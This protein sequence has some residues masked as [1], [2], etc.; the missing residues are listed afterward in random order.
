MDKI[1]NAPITSESV[2]E[3]IYNFTQ[4]AFIGSSIREMPLDSGEF[5]NTFTIL[6]AGPLSQQELFI[7]PLPIQRVIYELLTQYIIFFSMNP[8]LPFPPD[9]LA[10]SNPKLLGQKV[11]AYMAQHGWPFPQ[12]FG[13]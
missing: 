2:Q 5:A 10:Q 9:F 6:R 7:Q 8:S 13:Q 1:M 3:L 12:M 4:Y 11:T